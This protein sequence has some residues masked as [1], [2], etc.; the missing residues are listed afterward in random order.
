[1]S[2]CGV[3]SVIRKHWKKAG[4][5]PLGVK[6]HANLALEEAMRALKNPALLEHVLS[7]F[8]E[9]CLSEQCTN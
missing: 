9:A 6:M 7:G 2:W 5:G 4:P 1:M 3:D 8:C